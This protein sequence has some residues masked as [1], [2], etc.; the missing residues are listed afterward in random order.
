[1]APFPYGDVERIVQEELGVRL[2]KAF[3]EF[4]CQ[5]V[6]AASLGQVHRAVLRGGRVV[7]VKVQRPGIR[8]RVIEDLDALDEIASLV[9]RFSGA[10]RHVDA[11]RVLQEF[12]RTLMAELDYRRRR[13]TSRRSQRS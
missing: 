1:V 4:D 11:P 13:A 12:R 6:A 2:S 9:D 3:L 7:A 5:P 8:E 10:A